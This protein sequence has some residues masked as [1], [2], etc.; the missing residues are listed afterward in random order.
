MVTGTSRPAPEFVAEIP[1][2][3]LLVARGVPVTVRTA[4]ALLCVSE[5]SDTHIALQAAPPDASY[6]LTPGKGVSIEGGTEGPLELEIRSGDMPVLP[7][8]EF[9]LTITGADGRP[10]KS[11]A[12]A[13]PDGVVRISLEAVGCVNIEMRQRG[14]A[15]GGSP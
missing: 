5:Y 1:A 15:G 9:D 2:G 6:A 13:G 3:G 8:E 14:R 11:R 4:A 7:N 12:I 10:D